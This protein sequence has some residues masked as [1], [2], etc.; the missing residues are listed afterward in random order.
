[1]TCVLIQN[2]QLSGSGDRGIFVD[3]HS[4]TDNNNLQILDNSIA[5]EIG[6][7][8]DSFNIDT[9]S[10]V[11]SNTFTSTEWYIKDVHPD[12]PTYINIRSGV[13]GSTSNTYANAFISFLSDRNP[14]GIRPEDQFNVWNETRFYGFPNRCR[15]WL[16]ERK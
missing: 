6:L 12:L 2:N 3:Y 7:L 10:N 4:T 13:S 5:Y 8:A 15:Q 1:L 11:T 16:S 9:L 14:N